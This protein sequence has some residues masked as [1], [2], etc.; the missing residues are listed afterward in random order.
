MQPV[1]KW[2]EAASAS[3]LRSRT[4]NARPYKD[5]SIPSH[6]RMKW[7]AARDELG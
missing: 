2:G 5:V 7:N 3:A 6:K 4:S 1:T